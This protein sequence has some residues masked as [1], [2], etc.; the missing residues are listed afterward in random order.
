MPPP[1]PQK[2]CRLLAGPSGA[3]AQATL[4]F[5]ALLALFYKRLRETPPVRPLNVWGMDVSKQL[6]GAAAAHAAGLAVALF[7][8]AG[9]PPARAGWKPASECGWYAVAFTVDTLIGT[10]LAVWLH[11]AAVAAAGRRTGR[12]GPPTPTSAT[13]PPSFVHAVARCGDYGSPPRLAAFVPQALEWVACVVAARALCAVVVWL[14]RS[15]LSA[16]ASA[17]DAL[18]AGAAPATELAAVMVTGPLALNIAQA[19]VQDAVLAGRRRW[20]QPVP[21]SAGEARALSLTNPSPAH[22]LPASPRPS[23]DMEALLAPLPPDGKLAAGR[24]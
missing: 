14:L 17:V 18:F 8:A 6:L 19:L 12:G 4:A 15:P 21:V 24:S 13:A 7:V 16:A 2:T 1:P 23:G 5:A 20:R 3:L 22:P 11:R 10:G 9:P